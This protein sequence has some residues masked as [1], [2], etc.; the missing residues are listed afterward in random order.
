MLIFISNTLP[1]IEF[2]LGKTK[3]KD[4]TTRILLDSGAATNTGNNDYH[5]WIT[6]QYPDILE[7]YV[8]W[9]SVLKLSSLNFKFLLILARVITIMVLL[10]NLF[11]IEHLSPLTTVH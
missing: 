7:E 2:Y 10:Q 11:N 5:R 9:G 3:H 6:T 1:C 4:K 8:E